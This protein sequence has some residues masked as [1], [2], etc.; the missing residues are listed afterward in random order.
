MKE[1]PLKPSPDEPLSS[2]IEEYLEFMEVSGANKKTLKS[3]RSALKDF[4]SVVGDKRVGEV[5]YEDYVKWVRKRMKE[6]FP[7]SVK[8]DKRAQQT[9]LHY[10]SL[11]VRN[12]LKW[13]GL[14]GLPAVPKPRKDS[15]EALKPEEVAALLQ[16]AYEDP[17]DFLIVSLLLET[18]LRASEALNVTLDKVDFRRRQ[19]AVRGKYG[20][21]RVV[22]YGPLTEEASGGLGAILLPREG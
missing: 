12:F 5:K 2:A 11:F 22:F 10:Y 20:K 6:G 9:T 16:A 21:E 3:Y 7:R 4:L 18:G 17:I 1:P 13:L 8:K 15:V 14:E 19:I